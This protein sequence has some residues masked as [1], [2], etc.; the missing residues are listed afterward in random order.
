MIEIHESLRE[1]YRKIE[2]T[3]KGTFIETLGIEMYSIQPHHIFARV[4]ITPQL[5]Q[6]AGFLHGGV[7]LGISESL[8]SL[9]AYMTV[10]H[11][12]YAVFG[13]EINA[14]HLKSIRDGVIIAE[15]SA[16]HVGKRSQVWE[17]KI[18]DKKSK[19]LICVSRCTLAIVDKK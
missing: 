12:L 2:P 4:D 1:I 9:G 10:D 14:N 18:K 11:D 16:I 7:A 17:T 19:G 8:A 3:L 13:Q 5:L 15:A 6:P